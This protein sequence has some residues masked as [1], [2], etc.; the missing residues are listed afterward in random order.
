MRCKPLLAPPSYSNRR[1]H[2]SY[3]DGI[4]FRTIL[5]NSQSLRVDKL[6]RYGKQQRR[7]QDADADV[8]S[9]KRKSYNDVINKGGISQS[10]LW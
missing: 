4:L 7:K 10:V 6:T 5:Y 8:R 9:T 3:G 1:L 2:G